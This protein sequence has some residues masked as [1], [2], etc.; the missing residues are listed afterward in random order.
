MIYYLSFRRGMEENVFQEG[1]VRLKKEE[2][3]IPVLVLQGSY[4]TE[5]AIAR[6]LGRHHIPV[7]LLSRG[8]KKPL[9]YF[10]KFVKGIFINPDPL[11]DEEAFT[12]SVLSF[13]EVLKK[14]Y[15]RRIL[16]FPTDDGSLLL[17]ARNFAALK[18]YFVILNDPQGKDISRFSQKS[19]VFQTLQDSGCSDFLPLALFCY[20]N[21][22]VQSVKDNITFPCVIK[23]SEKD[24]NFSFYR[25]YNSKVLLVESKDN[26]ERKLTQLLSENQRLLVQELVSRKPAKE[27]SWYGYRSKSGEIF[28]MTARQVRKSPQMG[29]TATFLEAEEIPQIH[30]F[31]HRALEA[32]DFWG[33]CEMELMLDARKKEYKMIEFNP[34]SWLQL[35]LATRMGLN[36]PWLAYQEVYKNQLLR[37]IIYKKGRMR[38]IWVKE[39]FIRAVM[40]GKKAGA[41]KRLSE[42]MP[43]AF[44]DRV[45][46]VH[47][48]ADL[49]VTLNRILSLPA[50]I[51]KRL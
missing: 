18:K 7:F 4:L 13:G 44:G 49:R 11:E 45:Y 9:S 35:S 41:L 21:D 29:G 27:I 17:L 23:P 51:L 24:I 36:L 10:S 2:T 5:L 20:K 16:L 47:S 31:A 37:P 12:L 40:Q 39:D 50:R 6:S 26:L 3:E 43:E 33:I 30:P 8:E 38:W 25:K 19:Y 48:F 46:A 14:K 28:G 1:W 42:W 22:D 15:R 34:R 32:L